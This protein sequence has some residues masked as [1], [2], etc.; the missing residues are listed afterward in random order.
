MDEDDDIEQ[1][2]LKLVCRAR[3]RGKVIDEIE[4]PPHQYVDLV[5]KYSRSASFEGKELIFRHPFGDLSIK[6]KNE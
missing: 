6:V 3:D 1:W 4:L 5:R 2:L